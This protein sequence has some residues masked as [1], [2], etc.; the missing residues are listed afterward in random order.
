MYFLEILEHHQ[1]E[2]LGMLLRFMRAVLQAW[3]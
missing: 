3:L 1:R 2:D